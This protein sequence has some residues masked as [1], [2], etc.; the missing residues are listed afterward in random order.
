MAGAE[1]PPGR[2]SLG[3]TDRI[4]LAAL[5]AGAV[6]IA[7]AP[8]FVR[9]AETGPVGTAFYRLLFALPVLWLWMG[10]ER[11]ARGHYRR[12]SGWR[13]FLRLGAAGAFFAGDLAVWH[14]AILLTSVANATLFANFAPVFVTLGAWLLFGQRVTWIFLAGLATALA[15]AT[16]LIGD[17]VNLSLR[18]VAGDA[19]GLLTAVFYGGYLLSVSRLRA[20]FSTATIMAWS[21][22]VTCVGLL[23]IALLLDEP[24]LAVTA[25]GWAVLAGLALVSHVGGQGLIA[26]ALAHLAAPFSSV[27]LL[28]QPLVA[29]GLAWLLL[30][31]PVRPWQG[32]GGAVVLAGIFLARRGSRRLSAPAA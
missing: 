19:M 5:I 24:L 9:L 23:A 30:A 16:L 17:S 22:V 7:F 20:E 8:I 1:P 27:G 21:G 12:P 2:V 13:D 4:A 6:A 26:Y 32:V 29:A 31:E 15:G 18:N 14:G 10:L 3:S 11:P 25:A 28:L